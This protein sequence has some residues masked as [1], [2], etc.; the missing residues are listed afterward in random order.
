MD[1]YLWDQSARSEFDDDD[2]DDDE[3]KLKNNRPQSN[4]A[5]TNHCLSLVRSTVFPFKKR[6]HDTVGKQKYLLLTRQPLVN[7]K[8]GSVTISQ[9]HRNR[10]P[11]CFRVDCHV[12]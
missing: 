9:S 8:E 4:S 2:D 12:S 1:R 3:F 11:N 7:R 10:L 5:Q 6:V